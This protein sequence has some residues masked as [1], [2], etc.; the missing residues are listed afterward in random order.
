MTT[1]MLQEIG[2]AGDSSRVSLAIMRSGSQN[3][4]RV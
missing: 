1:H 2:G 3:L 4:R